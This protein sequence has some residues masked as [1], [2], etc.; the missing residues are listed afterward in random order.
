M[1]NRAVKL[2]SMLFIASAMLVACAGPEKVANRGLFG[3][4]S[5][6]KEDRVNVPSG[7]VYAVYVD[8]S[9]NPVGADVA[10]DLS[11]TKENKMCP[12]PDPGTGACPTGYCPRPMGGKTYC[13]RC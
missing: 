11:G 7:A 6:K 3:N 12:T 9:G 2:C 5:C 8:G 13:L 10:E 4:A 1:R